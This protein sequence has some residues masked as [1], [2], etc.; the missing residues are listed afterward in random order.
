MSKRT[1]GLD[2]MMSDPTG[3][4]QIDTARFSISSE[5]PVQILRPLRVKI[6]MYHHRGLLEC[7]VSRPN[8]Q[9]KWYKSRKE[10]LPS[11]KYQL[12]SQDI[13]RQLTIDDVCSSDEDTY[14]CDAGDDKTSCQLLVEGETPAVIV[15][16]SNA[17][18][19]VCVSHQS[20]ITS[21]FSNIVSQELCQRG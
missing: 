17:V 14:T 13:Y 15:I 8:A 20:T 6:A 16:I 2:E 3:L 11:K 21:V 12:I 18:T 7:Q 19:P 5:L 9:V 1:F 4:F 10:L